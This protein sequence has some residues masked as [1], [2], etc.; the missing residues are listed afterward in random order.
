[1]VEI[2]LRGNYMWHGGYP[3]E[4]VLI[5]REL[6]RLMTIF[7]ASPELSRRRAGEVKTN[8]YTHAMQQ[9]EYV[10]VSR[11]LVSVAAMLRNDWDLNP[12]L[13][14]SIVKDRAKSRSVGTLVENLDRPN[15]VKPL[16]PRDSFNKILH[17]TLMNLDRSEN[18]S[19]VSGHLE[20]RVH[21]YGEYKE[22]NWKATIEIFD[23]IE[24]VYWVS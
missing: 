6:Y 7:G 19:I 21:L 3:R 23:W 18:T 17:A 12:E 1:V 16:K 5:D 8:V 10:E 24:V 9:F 11:V 20:P 4:D 22:M 15:K 13:T 14:A 2:D